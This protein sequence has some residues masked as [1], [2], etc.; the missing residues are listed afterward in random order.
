MGKSQSYW[1]QLQ[2][3]ISDHLLHKD[4]IEILQNIQ[5]RHNCSRIKKCRDEIESKTEYVEVE[6]NSFEDKNSKVIGEEEEESLDGFLDD[7]FY[8]SNG[9][10][11]VSTEDGLI[12]THDT[13]IGR[14]KSRRVE[15]MGAPFQDESIFLEDKIDAPDDNHNS[16]N[17]DSSSK[18][19]N[20]SISI[21]MKILRLTSSESE[22]E[23]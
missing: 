5:D 2:H 22:K 7:G 15:L 12:G 19:A 14:M 8:F 23:F 17:Y 20:E 13:I 18:K 1:E 10:N 16:K 11:L 4:A 6:G 21:G 9:D 3:A